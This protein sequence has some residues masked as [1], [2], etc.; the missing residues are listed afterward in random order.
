MLVSNTL[1]QE[2]Q[3]GNV[4]KSRNFGKS[5]SGC[6]SLHN[7]KYHKMYVYKTLIKIALKMSRYFDNQFYRMSVCRMLII[8][9]VYILGYIHNGNQENE[10]HS[11]SLQIFAHTVVVNHCFW[12]SVRY[13]IVGKNCVLK[14]ISN[15]MTKP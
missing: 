1:C 3:D 9:G 11:E 15:S 2:S 14:E 13:W 12:L 10:G 6:G 4:W 5:H 7:Y 8:N